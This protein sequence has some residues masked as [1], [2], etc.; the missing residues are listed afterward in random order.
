MLYARGLGPTSAVGNL[1]EPFP[2]TPTPLVNSPV[3]VTINNVRAEV[4]AA[5]G[6]PGQTDVYQVRFVVPDGIPAGT[7]KLQLN[8]AWVSASPAQIALK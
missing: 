8:V 2:E 7:A 3:E 6:Y 5:A 1:G 4:Q